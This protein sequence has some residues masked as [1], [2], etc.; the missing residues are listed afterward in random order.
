VRER[1]RRFLLSISDDAIQ[2]NWT[3]YHSENKILNHTQQ[4]LS[5]P[6]SSPSLPLSPFLS[7][8]P[9][10]FLS[11]SHSPLPL[12]LSLIHLSF[13]QTSSAFPLSLLLYFL[14]L[15]FRISSFPLHSTKFSCAMSKL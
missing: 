10:F 9:S 1:E 4:S 11:L 12:S 2:E 5:P 14:Y 7:T 8:S 13:L 15:T 3:I 6:R